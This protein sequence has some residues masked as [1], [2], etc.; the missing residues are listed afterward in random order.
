M[1]SSIWRGCVRKALRYST[2]RLIIRR[3]GKVLLDSNT[4]DGLFLPNN[5]K[6]SCHK[7]AIRIFNIIRKRLAICKAKV[8]I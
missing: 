8:S 1:R 6:I 5:S 4:S 2:M 7:Y 3:E